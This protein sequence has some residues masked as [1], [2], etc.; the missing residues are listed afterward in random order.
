MFD[1]ELGFRFKTYATWW[2]QQGMHRAKD[3][4]DR[5]VRIP[6]HLKTKLNRIRR[7]QA[8]LADKIGRQPSPEELADVMGIRPDLLAKLMWRIHVTNVVEADAPI[9]EDLTI[10]D[11]KK[12]DEAESAFDLVADRELHDVMQE[13][14]MQLTPREE[15]IIRMRYGF[16]R[17]QNHT[18]EFVGQQ[19]GV[20]RERIR[21]IEA[22]ALRKLMNPFRMRMLKS[23][24]DN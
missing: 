10:M 3:N 21:Q 20:T 22:K 14:L 13:I 18:L 12:D 6:V 11:V 24:I 9:G 8:K 4:G 15:R 7:A 16:D 23:F 19:F 1:P 5:T 2:I 17:D